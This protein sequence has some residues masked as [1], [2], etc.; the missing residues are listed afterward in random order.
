LKRKFRNVNR[1]VETLRFNKDKVAVKAVE[2]DLDAVRGT[3]FEKLEK[4]VAAV[5]AK[6][7]ELEQDI[8]TEKSYAGILLDKISALE[9]WEE[10][11]AEEYE[12]EIDSL[13]KQLAD[14]KESKNF[15]LKLALKR[16][17]SNQQLAKAVKD[18]LTS[19]EK[20]QQIVQKY[21]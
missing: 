15:W 8:L 14:S 2:D 4:Y 19:F 1:S 21:D 10:K 13:K 12:S 18:G 20:L 9:Y 5:A 11:A 3:S 16:N 6:I 17:A 7:G